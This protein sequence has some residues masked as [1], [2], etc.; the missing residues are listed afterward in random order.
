MANS[1]K[2]TSGA[3]DPTTGAAAPSNMGVNQTTNKGGKN[4]S[5]PAPGSPRKGK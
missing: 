5:K 4:T 2:P 1:K 3:Y